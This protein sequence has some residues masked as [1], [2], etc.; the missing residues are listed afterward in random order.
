LILGENP[1]HGSGTIKALDNQKVLQEIQFEN[2][3]AS[4]ISHAIDHTKSAMNT[5]VQVLIRAYLSLTDL[6][7]FNI[8]KQTNIV[9]PKLETLSPHEKDKVFL[10]S[11]KDQNLLQ[12]LWEE[13]NKINPF[14]NE[15]NPFI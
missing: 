7:R 12:S 11:I 3:V 2:E 1:V 9:I 5:N 4:T 8:I 10:N 6:Q 13:V 15:A 14:E